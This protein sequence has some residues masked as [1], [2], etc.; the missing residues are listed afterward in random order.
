MECGEYFLKRS[1]KASL[2]KFPLSKDLNEQEPVMWH[3]GE[4]HSRQRKQPM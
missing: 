2:V 4:E 3:L 1:E